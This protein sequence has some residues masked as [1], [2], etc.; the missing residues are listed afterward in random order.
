MLLHIRGRQHYE[1]GCCTAGQAGEESWFCDGHGT[2]VPGV[3]GGEEDP[4]QIVIYH[5]QYPP[6]SSQHTHSA[7]KHIQWQAAVSVLLNGQTEELLC[8]PSHTA[9]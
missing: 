2:G 9:D 7:E 1:E 8:S 3:S 4:K 5:G 6:P